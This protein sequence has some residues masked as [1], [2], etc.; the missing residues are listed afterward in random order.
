MKARRFA[1]RLLLG[2]VLAAPFGG[3]TAGSGSPL[4]DVSGLP[5]SSLQFSAALGGASAS[6]LDGQGNATGSTTATL[7]ITNK[8]SGPLRWVAVTD[9]QGSWL[10]LSAGDGVIPSGG[11][12][13][14]LQ[15]G[16]DLSDPNLGEE[17]VHSALLTIAGLNAGPQVS[18]RV[19][20]TLRGVPGLALAPSSLVFRG[21]PG[22][23][24]PT[25]Q[26]VAISNVVAG[27][28]LQWTAA[29]TSTPPRWLTIAAATG[30]VPGASAAFVTVS[31]DLQ[32]LA[33]STYTG[34]ITFD[35]KGLFG[36][37]ATGTPPPPVTVPVT[38]QVL[39]PSLVLTSTD[40]LF[41]ANMLAPDPA[42]QTV[43]L[44]DAV[45]GTT[46][47]WNAPPTPA[48]WLSVAPSSG[49]ASLGFG[50][51]A[52]L[53]VHAGS[54]TVGT[55]STAVTFWAVDR[56][57]A[58]AAG[59]PV[60]LAVSLTMLGPTACPTFFAPTGYVCT[61]AGTGVPGLPTEGVQGPSAYLEAPT[62]LAYLG[63]TLLDGEAVSSAVWGV[64]VTS[65]PSTPTNALGQR[66][67][68]GAVSLFYREAGPWV[69]IGIASDLR[70][71]AF[72]G[73]TIG[74]AGRV[75]VENPT[76]ARV[77]L[78]GGPTAAPA[79]ATLA[80]AGDLGDPVTD[81]VSSSFVT[82]PLG[83]AVS[84][85][86]LFVSD[87]S[88]DRVWGINLGSLPWGVAGS[89]VP[90]CGALSFGGLGVT[91]PMGLAVG[92]PAPG[93]I[94]VYVADSRNQRV[95]S[96]A[97]TPGT[98]TV[99]DVVTGSNARAVAVDGAG[100]LYLGETTEI[101]AVN[102]GAGPTTVAGVQI[103]AGGGTPTVI[104]GQ[105]GQ[106]CTPG[107]LPCGDGLA[108]TLPGVLLSPLALTLDGSGRLFWSEAAGQN[109]RIRA[110]RL[111]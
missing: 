67:A 55:Y 92:P 44:L 19:V 106:G 98:A 10:K 94:T 15:V 50:A 66:V 68:S 73:E 49:T 46:L 86:V 2:L 29:A 62:A 104:A 84:G 63:G 111:W 16:V 102:L 79:G 27:S 85:S 17:G 36:D 31:V 61:V 80:L 5:G 23:S 9:A 48:P 42:T 13:A 3:C 82:V 43:A 53:S 64:N 105:S 88:A 103:A 81:G 70:G 45:Q 75:L 89:V 93:S 99:A 71:L 52:V 109:P 78:C 28:H 18:V 59:A 77:T 37:P 76:S 14:A 83:L 4:L 60:S 26:A 47:R 1:T 11:G 69:P 8:G 101:R 108:S 58:P 22:G 72:V 33:A 96:I 95:R 91:T 97:L 39:S 100:T 6:L 30:S 51:S 25:S 90:P 56:T 35:G 7:T 12:T 38:L 110:L 65:A 41:T 20:L 32:G 74:T 24:N 21:E 40:L 57:G 87:S 54:L 107:A 34:M